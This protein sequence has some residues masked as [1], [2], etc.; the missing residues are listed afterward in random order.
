MKKILVLI[1]VPLM[2]ILGSSCSNEVDLTAEWKDIPVVF[3]FLSSS[4]SVHYMRVEKAFIDNN[5]SAL[6]IAQRAD[7]LYYNDAV[8][9]VQ[10]LNSSDAPIT[11]QRVDGNEE[12][13]LRDQGTF[14][15]APNYIY[16]YVFPQGENW[17]Q[18]ASYEL[19]LNRGDNLPLVTASTVVLNDIDLRNPKDPD[20]VNYKPIN[21]G[22]ENFALEI[23]WRADEFPAF[24]D[25]TLLLHINEFDVS[26]PS[27][28]MP[29]TLEW[30]VARSLPAE[31][32]SNGVV[33]M[34]VRI[35]GTEFFTFLGNALEQQDNIFRKFQSVDII[36]NSGGQEMKEYIDVGL[37]NVGIT[38]SQVVPTYTNLSEG[39]GIFSSRN[40]YRVNDHVIDAITVDSLIDGFYTKDLNFQF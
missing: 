28:P 25:V 37:V 7:S 29:K 32:P 39:F 15:T 26:N 16:K 38:S 23:K 19:K 8:V 5:T 24:F 27:V 21:W 11:F 35:F 17:E 30:E 22:N 31:D 13:I 1:I 14:A 40:E 34:D 36:I 20:N 18:G 6:D 33:A 3:G 10:K 4:D 12:G 9:Q 2:L